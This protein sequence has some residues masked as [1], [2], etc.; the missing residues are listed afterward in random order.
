MSTFINGL[1]EKL[2]SDNSAYI[3]W[4]FA[5]IFW[6]LGFIFPSEHNL[7]VQTTNL[8]RGLGLA[9]LNCLGLYWRDLFT[10]NT[11]S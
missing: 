11:H 8:S 4:V 5:S 2:G 3:C 9:I 10:T 7:Q 1:V 6:N